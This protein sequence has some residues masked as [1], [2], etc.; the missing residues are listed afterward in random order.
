M[1]SSTSRGSS[2]SARPT[3]SRIAAAPRSTGCTPRKVPFG[4]RPTAVRAPETITASFIVAPFSRTLSIPQRLPG[5]QHVRDPFVRLL[6]FQE[7]HERLSLK[8]EQVLLGHPLRQRE[9]ASCEDAGGVSGYDAVVLGG[10]AAPLQGLHLHLER[11]AGGLAGGVDVLA[12]LGGRVAVGE[13][14]D[15]AP[16]GGEEV[17]RVHHHA[18]VLVEEAHL[19]RF[20]GA[21]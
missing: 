4:A 8:L 17:V 14:E 16:G 5:L 6:V 2:P 10:V 3:A 1:T 21:G 12:A 20:E 13:V 7:V 19:L 18:V 15:L 9:V 11:G